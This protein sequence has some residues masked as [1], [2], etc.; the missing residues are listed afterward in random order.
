MQNAEDG[1]PS[2]APQ[3]G[4]RVIV[5]ILASPMADIS[6]K[7][8]A[9][10]AKLAHLDLRPEETER[11]SR[12]LRQILDYARSLESLPIDDVPP[13]SHA[14]SGEI[15]RDDAPA[16]ELPREL[17]LSEAPDAESGLFRVPRVLGG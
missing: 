2:A 7:T 6:E 14:A 16:A 10:L 12:H 11:F 13:M 4:H 3:L 1:S 8:I 15:L 17:A 9:H 5:V